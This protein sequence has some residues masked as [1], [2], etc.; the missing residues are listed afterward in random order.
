M[1]W[2]IIPLVIWLIAGILTLCHKSQVS[3]LEY[4]LIWTVLI[5]NLI[6]NIGV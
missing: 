1:I 6:A 4:A 3:K 2:D 5:L